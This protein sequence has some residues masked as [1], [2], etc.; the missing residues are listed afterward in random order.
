MILEPMRSRTSAHVVVSD[1]TWY[2][3][4]RAI[5]SPRLRSGIGRDPRY[6]RVHDGLAA[7]AAWEGDNE[8]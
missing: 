2:D 5:D 8:A 3:T 6:R 1:H 7:A 4:R